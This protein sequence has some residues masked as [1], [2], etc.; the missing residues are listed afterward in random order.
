MTS[1]FLGRS[2][3]RDFLATTSL[4]LAALPLS[5]RPLAALSHADR[6]LSPIDLIDPPIAADELRAFALAALDAARAAGATYADVRVSD[7][8]HLSLYAGANGVLFGAD[9][10][11]EFGIRVIVNG[12]TSFAYGNL[13]DLDL[14]T[15]AAKNAVASARG[16]AGALALP[17]EL[18][19]A[20]VVR[21]EWEASIEVDPFEVPL[22]AQWDVLGGYASIVGRVKNAEIVGPSFH[23][24]RETRVFA[25]TDG[26]LL[27]QRFH[28]ARIDVAFATSYWGTFFLPLGG[29]LRAVGG[30]ELATDPALHAHLVRRAEEVVRLASYPTTT[31][32]VGRKNVVMTG[33]AMSGLLAATVT[34]ALELDRALG[35]EAGAT[36]TSYLMPVADVIGTQVF[37]PLVT[38]STAR[39]TPAGERAR[40]DDDGVEC[41]PTTVIDK[42]RVVDF[43]SSRATAAA[44]RPWYERQGRPV[45]SNGNCTAPSSLF[46]PSP[47]AGHTTLHAGSGGP[48]LDALCR[49]LKNGI[50]IYD[51]R[52]NL[53]QQLSS[54]F[55]TITGFEVVN[56]RKTRLIKGAGMQMMT[57]RTWAKSLKA[58]GGDE[59]MEYSTYTTLKSQPVQID[60]TT[61]SAPAALLTDVDVVQVGV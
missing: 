26:T 54:A 27:T 44:L 38:V 23:W 11:F 9:G 34:P 32:D 37:S 43:M 24:T 36:G 22:Q 56:G 15:A 28:R 10:R 33:G 46:M 51:A 61:S 31:I 45:R 5:T 25:S 14:M 50:L 52:F 42:G 48:T 17:T 19:P 21:G 40:W 1:H 55:A 7:L 8:P 57:K 41:V 4:A 59:T 6:A 3:R 53:D 29:P 12:A 47:R 20:P 13:P 16:L 49:E 35:Y 60:Q 18:A 58:L 39:N 2:S 30:F